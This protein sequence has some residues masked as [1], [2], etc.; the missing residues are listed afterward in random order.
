MAG[1]PRRTIHDFTFIHRWSKK[2]P[3]ELLMAIDALMIGERFPAGVI[4]A[5]E[6]ISPE[7]SICGRLLGRHSLTSVQDYRYGA[8]GDWARPWSYILQTYWLPPGVKGRE[9]RPKVAHLKCLGMEPN[10][11]DRL[12][13]SMITQWQRTGDN[14]ETWEE[15]QYIHDSN[16]VMDSLEFV[17][18]M[19]AED[20]TGK[21]YSIPI[22]NAYRYKELVNFTPAERDRIFRK[23][24]VLSAPEIVSPVANVTV[25][26][27]DGVVY[28]DETRVYYLAAEGVDGWYVS[29]LKES[30]RAH[31]PVDMLY[32]YTDD[33]PY[34]T[35]KEARQAG[36][37]NAR[38]FFFETASGRTRIGRRKVWRN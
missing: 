9:I 5:S 12:I 17:H 21:Y 19:E 10:T 11:Q 24:T 15:V 22:P 3:R 32:L 37:D 30:D 8:R 20:R 18:G 2:T 7:C 6:S 34:L 35:R 33:G 13:E 23:T 31:G 14:E 28:E 29:S 4:L 25:D 27:F 26:E 1:M 38:D 16:P 36:E